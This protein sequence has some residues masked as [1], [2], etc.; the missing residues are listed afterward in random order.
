MRFRFSALG[1]YFLAATISFLT[2]CGPQGS[3]QVRQTPELPVYP[4]G[5]FPVDPDEGNEASFENLLMDAPKE[6]SF[7]IRYDDADLDAVAS[8]SALSTVEYVKQLGI[9]LYRMPR[10]EKAKAPIF[11]RTLPTPPAYLNSVWKQAS[12][13]STDFILGLYQDFCTPKTCREN[14]VVKPVILVDEASE[15]WTLVH[16]MLHFSIEDHLK[17]NGETYRAKVNAQVESLAKSLEATVAEYDRTKDHEE[18]KAKLAD[19]IMQQVSQLTEALIET[20][21]KGY[22]EETAIE[23]LLLEKWS[24]GRLEFVPLFAIE[25]ASWYLKSSQENGIETLNFAELLIAEAAEIGELHKITGY[26]EVY[27]LRLAKIVDLR[28]ESNSL[29]EKSTE[30]V[31]AAKKAMK[32][33][34]PNPAQIPTL[35][36]SAALTSSMI[37]PVNRAESHKGCSR[38][39]LDHSKLIKVLENLRFAR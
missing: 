13:G 21:V 15:R 14:A 24:K 7:G 26:D 27:M 12:E 28:S 8:S 3:P 29:I 39:H 25:N 31:R 37:D 34:S 38:E 35:S 5:T 36:E 11:F 16:E 19:Q 9:E 6:T 2:A 30:I 33:Q 1:S 17:R 23:Y 22:F 18:K 20:T 4:S 10:P 32:N